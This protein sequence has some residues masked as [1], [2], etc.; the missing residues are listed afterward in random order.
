MCACSE[1]ER[2]LVFTLRIATAVEL[3]Q[4]GRWVCVCVGGGGGDSS[5]ERADLLEAAEHGRGMH[6]PDD[7]D[8]AAAA[9]TA[10]SERA[11]E[12]A[13]K[14]VVVLVTQKEPRLRGM[15]DVR[16]LVALT[17]HLPFFRMFSEQALRHLCQVGCARIQPIV[18]HPPCGRSPPCHRPYHDAVLWRMP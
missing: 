17:R 8:D 16:A 15:K 2:G 7:D 12:A 3:S 10:E 11:E 4:T 6:W 9:A 1:C 18:P 5:V 13:V 14:A